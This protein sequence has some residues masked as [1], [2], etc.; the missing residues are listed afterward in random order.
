MKCPLTLSIRSPSRLLEAD[1][2]LAPI[3]SRK[4]RISLLVSIP[5]S[6][7][8]SRIRTLSIHSPCR[9]YASSAVMA[10]R[11]SASSMPPSPIFHRAP[12]FRVRILEANRSTQPPSRHR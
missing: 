1:F 4:A 3:F 6:F 10:A 7:A 2:P 8:R 5:R 11:R 12:P 9:S